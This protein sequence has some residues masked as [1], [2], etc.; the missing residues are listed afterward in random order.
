MAE[1]RRQQR[2]ESKWPDGIDSEELSLERIKIKDSWLITIVALITVILMWIGLSAE[3]GEKIPMLVFFA[4]FDIPLMLWALKSVT[5]SKD[6][7]KISYL[8]WKREYKWEE[9]EIVR[10]DCFHSYRDTNSRGIVF[11]KRK[12]NKAGYT[13]KTRE[14]VNTGHPLEHFYIILDIDGNVSYKRLVKKDGKR[15]IRKFYV[16]VPEKLNE[17]GVELERGDNMSPSL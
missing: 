13:Y 2:S 16:N 5:L 4:L 15:M 12:K 17:W 7:C 10:E 11:S 1:I 6:G 9:L 14:I 8:F 3:E